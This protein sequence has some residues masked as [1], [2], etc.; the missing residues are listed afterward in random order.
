MK[1]LLCVLLSLPGVAS[2]WERVDPARPDEGV[3][4]VVNITD[5]VVDD[6][7]R[8]VGMAGD[9][10]AAG[11]RQVLNRAPDASVDDMLHRGRFLRLGRIGGNEAIALIPTVLFARAHNVRMY[12]RLV[13]FNR[14]CAIAEVRTC[15]DPA[16]CQ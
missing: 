2:A 16:T 14:A 5:V 10:P 13:E 7:D 3:F 11:C 6:G 9:D 8:F 15:F 1:A 12:V 4:T